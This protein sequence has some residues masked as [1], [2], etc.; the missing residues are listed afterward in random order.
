[1]SNILLFQVHEHIANNI[2][3]QDP[4]ATNYFGS[5]EVGKFLTDLMYPGA[6]VDWREHLQASI[7]QELSASAM[8]NYFEPLMKY[9]KKENKGRKHTLPESPQY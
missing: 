7:G 3:K 9:L 4:H 8:V 5:K 2:L 1:M 6:S